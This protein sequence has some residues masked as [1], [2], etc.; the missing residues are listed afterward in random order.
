MRAFNRA[1]AF[2]FKLRPAVSV[3]KR[4]Q[5]HSYDCRNE[6][7]PPGDV[8]IVTGGIAQNPT[9]F[10]LTSRASLNGLVVFKRYLIFPGHGPIIDFFPVSI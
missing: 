9:L 8:G 10:K 2:S 4:H 6:N 5:C 3:E 1:Q 7:Q